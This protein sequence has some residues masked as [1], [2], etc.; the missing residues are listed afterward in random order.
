MQSTGEPLRAYEAITISFLHYRYVLHRIATITSVPY[1]TA[2]VRLTT[3]VH[4]HRYGTLHSSSSIG[5]K[6]M[7]RAGSTREKNRDMKYAVLPKISTSRG[8]G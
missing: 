6:N 3:D 4:A 7:T 8:L 2:A 1:Q 5:V